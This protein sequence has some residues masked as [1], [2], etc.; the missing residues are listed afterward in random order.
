MNKR[1]L[2][3]SVVL[4][5]CVGLCSSCAAKSSDKQLA[6]QWAKTHFPGYKIEFVGECSS[7]V[8]D[9]AGKHVVYIEAL[10]STSQGGYDG[11]TKKGY[12]VKYTKKVK[13]GKKSTSY[14]VW[15]PYTNYCDDVVAFVDHGKIRAAEISAVQCPV[16]NWRSEKCPYW[17]HNEHRHMTAREIQDFEIM[18]MGYMHWEVE[19]MTQNEKNSL[20]PWYTL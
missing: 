7:K 9:R 13:K 6:K 14:S 15:N 1:V 16:C 12:Y 4:I 8:I 3:M 2:L 17:V 18:E 20:T 5:I 11:L 10:R 19:G